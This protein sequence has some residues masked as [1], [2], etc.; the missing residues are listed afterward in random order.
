MGQEFHKRIRKAIRL[1]QI[2]NTHKAGRL[3][4][5]LL[6]EQPNDVSVLHFAGLLEYQKGRVEAGVRMISRAITLDERYVD[7][8]LNL[9]NILLEQDGL[10]EA[11]ACYLKASQLA[12]ERVDIVGNL[13]VL[14]RK[15]GQLDQSEAL[16][17]Q[18]V[19]RAPQWAEAHFHLSNTLYAA[20]RFREAL[21]CLR[22]AMARN[23]KLIEGHN[24]YAELCRLSGELDEARSIYR[25]WLEADP[26]N[27]TL[28]HMLLALDPDNPPARAADAYIQEAF[29]SYANTFEGHLAHLGYRGPA[30]LGDTLE[31]VLGEPRASLEVLDAGCG[32]GL[33]SAQL[34]PYARRLTGIDLS[35]GMLQKA[36]QT[37]RYDQLQKREITAFLQRK[38]A[39][40]DLIAAMDVLIYLGDLRATLEALAQSLRPEGICVLSFEGHGDDE[41]QG[42]RIQTSGRFSHSARYLREET[43]HAGLCLARLDAASVRREAGV[44][45][46]GW[47]ITAAR[48]GTEA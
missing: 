37:N 19:A 4:K 30:L 35:S 15:M 28:Q 29:D 48:S 43:R 6:K 33:C 12:P 34:R 9:G 3:Y 10:N 17:K 13:G 21:D 25:Q 22:Q 27:A 32:T 38:P 36:G 5:Q 46:P 11:H 24:R 42:Y 20:G 1:H 8:Y 39:A 44:D 41:G 47:L 14:L 31:Q 2:G 7:A 45:V 23:P 26:G 18:L 16:L 40:F